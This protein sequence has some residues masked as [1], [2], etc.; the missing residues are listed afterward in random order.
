MFQSLEKNLQYNKSMIEELLS[1][2]RHQESSF[3]ESYSLLKIT[4]K[5]SNLKNY[6]N[7]SSKVLNLAFPLKDLFEMADVLSKQP[8]PNGNRFSVLHLVIFVLLVFLW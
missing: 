1:Y 7:P 3:I 2:L 5:I 4:S 8:L 6:I